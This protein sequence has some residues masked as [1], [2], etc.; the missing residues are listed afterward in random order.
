[1][2]TCESRHPPEPC[3]SNATTTPLQVGC[4]STLCQ[5][6][7]RPSTAISAHHFLRNPQ[8][9]AQCG[10]PAAVGAGTCDASGAPPSI[11]RFWSSGYIQ[12][13]CHLG[14]PRAMSC[15][16]SVG[17]RLLLCR[18]SR[19]QYVALIEIAFCRGVP[20]EPCLAEEE[21][22]AVTTAPRYMVIG[23]CPRGL[24]S[25]GYAAPQVTFNN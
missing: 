7:I 12:S 23:S 1:M 9:W 8:D 19:D 5:K 24:P 14:I 18:S 22:L 16:G 11:P 2:L 13:S 25:I 17:R 21:V 15:Q 6:L 3:I 4:G 20:S 10:V